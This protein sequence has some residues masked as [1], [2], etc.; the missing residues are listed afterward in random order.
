MIGHGLII[1]A[2][3]VEGSLY[4]SNYFCICLNFIITE[5]IKQPIL[6]LGVHK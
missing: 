2:V 1:V 5:N 3:G 6:K 4:Y